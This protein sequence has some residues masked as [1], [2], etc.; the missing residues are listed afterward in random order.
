MIVLGGGPI[1]VELAQA[2]QRFGVE[3]TIVEMG[4]QI[5]IRE[6]KELRDLLAERL[7]SDGLKILTDTK[8]VKLYHENGAVLLDVEYKSGETG[9]INAETVLIAVGRKANVDGL[10]LEKAGVEYLQKGIKV[11]GTLKTTAP[12]IYACGDVA[13]PYQFSHMAEYQARIAVQNVLLPVK[14]HTNYEHYIWC[15]F[16]DPEL[17]HAG[18]TEEEARKEH[19]KRIRGILWGICTSPRPIK[20]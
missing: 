19:G 6:D 3:I 16:T 13:G 17:A 9:I 2:L 5:L 14:K 15:T 12:N 20:T 8:A 10:M 1:G 18:L 11:D 7:S 4:S